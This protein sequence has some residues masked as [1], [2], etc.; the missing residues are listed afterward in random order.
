MNS[1]S[2]DPKERQLGNLLREW[3]VRTEAPPGFKREVWRRIDR[4]RLP[5]RVSWWEELR[6]LI[7]RAF[8]SPLLAGAYLTLLLATGL[9]TG[10]LQARQTNT[11]FRDSLQTRYVQSVDPYYRL[12]SFHR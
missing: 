5:N 6:L 3:K 11:Q 8:A 12:V 9:G 4:A 10:Y 7:D 1:N 2:T